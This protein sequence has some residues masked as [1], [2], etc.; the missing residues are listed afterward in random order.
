MQ[1]KILAFCRIMTRWGG[2]GGSGFV[3]NMDLIGPDFQICSIN[4]ARKRKN[5]IISATKGNC[6]GLLI[7]RHGAL[8]SGYITSIIIVTDIISAVV[9]YSDVGL[10]DKLASI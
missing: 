4:D 8:S 5:N 1:E 7:K 3:K 6:P 9:S 2:G 10:D